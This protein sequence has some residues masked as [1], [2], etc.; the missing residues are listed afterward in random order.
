[1]PGR[2]L[3]IEDN[4]TNL[5][6]IAYLLGSFGYTVLPAVDGEEGLRV[7]RRERPDVIICDVQ[8]PGIDGYEV[9]RRLKGD[10]AFRKVP[11][12]AVTAYA[13]VGDRERLVAA[14]FDGY[15]AKPIEREAFVS[16]IEMMLNTSQEPRALPREAAAPQEG[17][18][19]REPGEMRA[20][21]LVID[22]SLI[23]VDV[24]R[25]ALESV[26]YR[27]IGAQSLKEV[28][29]RDWQRPPDLI[30]CD[31]HMPEADGFEVLKR[32]R[33]DPCLRSA[34]FVFLS[35]SIW[36]QEDGRRALTL[37]GMKFIA[38]PIEPPQLIAEIEAC[39][40]AAGK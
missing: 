19:Q 25:S 4:A 22:N 37:G 31:V 7:A 34:Y 32:V 12:I 33:M 23:N 38:R 29:N 6:L 15:I 18:Q 39:L 3:V 26:G 27:V 16:K 21:I 14:G 2:V 10:P 17:L 5:D 9:A 24:V 8:L 36:P 1:L 28:L 35:S 40:K 11:L 13:M 30:L 20:T